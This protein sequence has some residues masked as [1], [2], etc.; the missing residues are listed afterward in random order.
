MPAGRCAEELKLH[1][2]RTAPRAVR[3]RV[4]AIRQARL[5]PFLEPLHP[6]V[7]RLAADP[8]RAAQPRHVPAATSQP[9]LNESLALFHRSGVLPRH[10]GSVNHQVG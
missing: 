1:L 10:L 3:A 5:A 4:R 8:V 9:V 2:R 6:L 7:P